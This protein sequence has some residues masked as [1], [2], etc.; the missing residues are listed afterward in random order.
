MRKALDRRKSLIYRQPRAIPYPHDRN[1]LAFAPRGI[2]SKTPFSQNFQISLSTQLTPHGQSLGRSNQRS[3]KIS[4]A[5]Y[6]HPR[7]NLNLVRLFRFFPLPVFGC[8]SLFLHPRDHKPTTPFTYRAVLDPRVK[9]D[10]APVPR[11]A[12]WPTILCHGGVVD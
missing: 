1:Y 6:S 7:G 8:L 12:K 4:Q 10:G 5:S 9:Y 2:T 11:D 3:S